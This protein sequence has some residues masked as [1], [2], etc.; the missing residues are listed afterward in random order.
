MR[1]LVVIVGALLALFL[2]PPFKNIYDAIMPMTTDITNPL[3]RIIFIAIPYLVP[4]AIG[5]LLFLVLRK[6]EQS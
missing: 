1:F 4:V 5:V 6:R 2:V 3:L